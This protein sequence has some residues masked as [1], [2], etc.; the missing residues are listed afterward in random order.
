MKWDLCER[1]E[2]AFAAYLESHVS[3]DMRVYKAWSMTEPQYPC[4]IVHCG[5]SEPIS[6]DASF[7]DPRYVKVEV[8]VGVESTKKNNR[9][10]REVNAAIRS[11]VMNALAVS[12][13][14]T[15][16]IAVGIEGVAF[17]MAEL[18]TEQ[19]DVQDRVLLTV[20]ELLVIAEPVEGT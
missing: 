9:T 5:E 15:Q 1:T 12:D 6:E 16:L 19:R 10:I 18:A 20:F 3:G 13:L 2:D 7:H 14:N 4:A 11:D 17:S 8:S